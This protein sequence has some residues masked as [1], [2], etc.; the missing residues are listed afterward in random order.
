MSAESELFTNASAKHQCAGS[1]CFP[2]HYVA[3]RLGCKVALIRLT[4][5]STAIGP[6]T[7]GNEKWIGG[8]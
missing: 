6:G 3:P 8:Q 4:L 2:T 5:E 7:P 1:E